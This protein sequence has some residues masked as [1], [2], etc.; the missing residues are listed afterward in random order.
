MKRKYSM[1][2]KYPIC[3]EVK[4]VNGDLWDV[5]DIRDTK[6]GFD[7]CFGAPA[8]NHGSYRGGLPR[9][10]ATKA[11]RDFWDANRNENNG[12]IFDLPA[13]RTTLI[14]VRRRLGFNFVD[15]RREFWM[16]RIEELGS[17]PAC[18]FAARHGVTQVITFQ[19]R[20]K[21]IGIRARPIGWWRTPETR[22]ILLSG[23][24]F[25]QM[26]RKLG[27]SITHSKRLQKQAKAEVSGRRDSLVNVQPDTLSF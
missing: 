1:K 25:S 6:H 22:S 10:I 20:R 23:I 21:M 14:R 2:R 15:D 5:R 26:G 17:L 27:I 7:L 3:G 4:D 13:G 16:D 11:L 18:E 12:V 24:A 19:R 8:G 9:L